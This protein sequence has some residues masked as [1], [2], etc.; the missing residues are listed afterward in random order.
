MIKVLLVLLVFL[1]WT[2]FKDKR[3]TKDFSENVVTSAQLLKERKVRN[4]FFNSHEFYFHRKFIVLHN[5]FYG[6]PCL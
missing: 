4:I 1:A 5:N 3:V 2:V 6:Q